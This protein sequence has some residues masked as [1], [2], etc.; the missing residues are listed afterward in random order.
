MRVGRH[1]GAFA[2]YPHQAEIATRGAECDVALV[3]Q[4]DRGALRAAPQAMAPPT[5]PPPMTMRS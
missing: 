4:C 3:D 2:L 1:A 5:R